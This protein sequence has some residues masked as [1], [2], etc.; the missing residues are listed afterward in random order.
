MELNPLTEEALPLKD[1]GKQL[2]GRPRYT[3]ILSWCQDG[4]VNNNTGQRVRMEMVQL[5]AGYAS[6]V[7]AYLRFIDRLNA[8]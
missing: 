2:P 7:A 3:T 8:F 5:P 6:S 1:L 4:R